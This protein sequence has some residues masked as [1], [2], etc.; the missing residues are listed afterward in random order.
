MVKILLPGCKRH[1]ARHKGQTQ[2]MHKGALTVFM[3]WHFKII[4]NKQL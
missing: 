1:G 4:T 2:V 3:V